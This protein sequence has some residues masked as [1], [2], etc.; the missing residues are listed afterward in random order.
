M[1]PCDSVSSESEFF[2][3]ISRIVSK[4]SNFCANPVIKNSKEICQMKTWQQS[5]DASQKNYV[6][7]RSNDKEVASENRFTKEPALD[8][9]QNVSQSIFLSFK[10]SDTF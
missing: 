2:L 9:C 1:E 5:P 10:I 3:V 8:C 7:R 4:L 6:R